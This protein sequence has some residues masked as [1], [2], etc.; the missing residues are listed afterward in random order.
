MLEVESP[1]HRADFI[2]RRA[3][4]FPAEVTYQ[5][6]YSSRIELCYTHFDFDITGS[7]FV[8]G[9]RVNSSS[10]CSQSPNLCLMTL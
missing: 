7:I 8:A 9:S 10:V 3:D 1:F 4:S 6:A 2:G 5:R